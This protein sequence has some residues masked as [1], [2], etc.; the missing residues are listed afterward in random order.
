VDEISAV[1]AAASCARTGRDGESIA[2]RSQ[3]SRRGVTE[4][5]LGLVDEILSPGLNGTKL[6]YFGQSVALCE[7]GEASSPYFFARQRSLV[8]RG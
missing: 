1:N 5:G 3:R 6:G 4:G 7:V 2:R 8:Y